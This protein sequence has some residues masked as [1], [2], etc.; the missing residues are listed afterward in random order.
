MY[1]PSSK[2]QNDFLSSCL[3]LLPIQPYIGPLEVKLIFYFKRPKNHYRS[4]KKEL[5]LKE[6]MDTWHCKKKDLGL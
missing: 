5:L 3:H 6:D 4:V 2:M 1:N